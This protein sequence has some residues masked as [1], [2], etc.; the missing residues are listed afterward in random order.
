M[1]GFDGGRR[2]V[3]TMKTMKR[4]RRRRRREGIPRI[5]AD[6]RGREMGS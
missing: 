5:H 4:R 2:R 1:T 6:E 3:T